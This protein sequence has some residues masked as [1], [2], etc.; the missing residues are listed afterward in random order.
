VVAAVWGL[1]FV[2]IEVGLRSLP[3]VLFVALHFAA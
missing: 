3:P 2:V 1:N